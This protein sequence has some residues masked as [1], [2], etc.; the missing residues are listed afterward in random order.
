MGLATRA[1]VSSACD[2]VPERLKSTY[3]R[4]S[5]PVYP[6]ETIRTEFYHEGDIVRFR[7][8]SVERDLI[9]LDRGYATIVG[10]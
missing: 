8:R 3:V 1:L 9:V 5:Q 7:C 6:G 4:F 2:G 10:Q